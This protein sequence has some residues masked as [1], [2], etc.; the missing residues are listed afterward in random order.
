MKALLFNNVVTDVTEVAFEVHKSLVWMD[1]PIET[2]VGFIL[3]NGVLV[4][5]PSEERVLTWS[6]V[7]QQAYP[8]LNDQ[9]DMQYHDLVDG[10]T[11]WKDSIAAVKAAH[12]KP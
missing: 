7:R 9:A 11:T 10:T 1:C 6:D 5:A 12:P 4:E 3:V 8:S 2:K